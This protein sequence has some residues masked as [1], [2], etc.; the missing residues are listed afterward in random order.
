MSQ[1]YQTQLWKLN[2]KLRKEM[3]TYLS[4]LFTS[5]YGNE[6]MLHYVCPLCGEQILNTKKLD[7]KSSEITIDYHH[8]V[9][10][11]MINELRSQ[12]VDHYRND[13]GSDRQR[14]EKTAEILLDKIQDGIYE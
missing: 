4:G 5:K 6:F 2:R 10:G 11:R 3:R 1:S 14:K 12:L 13:C 9:S 7:M 8:E